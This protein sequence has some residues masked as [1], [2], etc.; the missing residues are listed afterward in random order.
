MG[1]LE[2]KTITD[3]I[4]WCFDNEV[5][6]I[7]TPVRKGYKARVKLTLKAMNY[8]YFKRGNIEY[9][10]NSPE[11]LKKVHDIYTWAYRNFYNTK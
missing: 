5:Y 7:Q 4:D 2:N 11:L 3:M 9:I 8:G 6:V 1:F 10:Q